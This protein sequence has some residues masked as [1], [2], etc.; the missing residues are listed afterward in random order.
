M[1]MGR[2]PWYT[3]LMLGTRERPIMDSVP[4]LL[5]CPDRRSSSRLNRTERNQP[6]SKPTLIFAAWFRIPSTPTTETT[7]PELIADNT[8]KDP[9]IDDTK[10]EAHLSCSPVYT[11]NYTTAPPAIKNTTSRGRTSPS[12]STQPCIVSESTQIMTITAGR[13]MLLQ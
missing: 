4:D 9:K 7:S 13:R 2:Q 5:Q 6:W 8:E 11:S 12:S 3:P 10:A 1:A